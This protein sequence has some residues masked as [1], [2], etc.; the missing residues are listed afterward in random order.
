MLTFARIRTSVP[1]M[2]ASALRARDA[3]ET[4]GSAVSLRFREPHGTGKRRPQV[5]H[6]YSS[7]IG[8]MSE[9]C[10]TAHHCAPNCARRFRAPSVCI[11]AA[12]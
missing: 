6:R 9:S 2:D 12:P 5:R 7:W 3:D 1:A 10:M 11:R 4:N 8:H